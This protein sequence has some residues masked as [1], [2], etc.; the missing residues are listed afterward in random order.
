MYYAMSTDYTGSS[1]N[2]TVEYADFIN[3]T[4]SPHAMGIGVVYI[5]KVRV[6][7]QGVTIFKKNNGTA[8]AVAGIRVNF[9]KRSAEKS[10]KVAIVKLNTC[11]Y[12][13]A[14]R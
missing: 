3:L 5:N 2:N 9:T 13:K 11:P 12:Y 7:F 6:T 10:T 8:L 14:E 1:A 4:N